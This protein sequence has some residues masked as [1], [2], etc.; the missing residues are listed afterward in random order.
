MH[1]GDT[2]YGLYVSLSVCVSKSHARA[3]GCANVARSRPRYRALYPLG[4]RTNQ[5]VVL[6]G[7]NET[8]LGCRKTLEPGGVSSGAIP[9]TG[10]E[11]P[12]SRPAVP[13]TPPPSLGH[14]ATL[15]AACSAS[16]Q[17]AGTPVPASRTTRGPSTTEDTC[18]EIWPHHP[19]AEPLCV[20]CHQLLWI[21]DAQRNVIRT[22]APCMA[23]VGTA[24]S[25][26]SPRRLTG[27]RAPTATTGL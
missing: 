8:S 2:F 26:W 11:G 20:L 3:C 6:S 1:N 5:Q 7:E 22:P 9:S 18:P 15:P 17:G 23:R 13:T 24:S 21:D 27:H 19:F 14:E 4:E 10:P 12:G 25:S 16:P